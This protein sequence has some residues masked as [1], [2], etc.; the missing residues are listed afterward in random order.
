MRQS[1]DSR[2]SCTNN[3]DVR[4]TIGDALQELCQ[5]SGCDEHY[6]WACFDRHRK[7]AQAAQLKHEKLA[8]LEKME[9]LADDLENQLLVAEP[10]PVDT[11]VTNVEWA[12]CEH[13]A[14]GKWS[15]LPAHVRDTTR[16]AA[17][18]HEHF[19]CTRSGTPSTFIL[20]CTWNYNSLAR[21]HAQLNASELPEHFF[22]AMSSHW[23][24]EHWYSASLCPATVDPQAMAHP[25]Q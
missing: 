22:C 3:D 25:Q 5:T 20:I 7:L 10:L 12:Q 24:K 8:R 9:R 19:S 13:I 6:V 18:R 15:E 4:G 17:T 11:S 16:H 23:S 21:S 2:R 14:C 1:R